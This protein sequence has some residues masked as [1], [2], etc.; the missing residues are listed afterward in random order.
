MKAIGTRMETKSR[1]L[2]TDPLVQGKSN[3]AGETGLVHILNSGKRGGTIRHD[4][5]LTRDSE[6]PC[7]QEHNN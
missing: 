7:F 2:M 6:R 1:V 5:K 3:A 4:A